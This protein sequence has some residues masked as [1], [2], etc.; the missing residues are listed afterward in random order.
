[1]NI[2]AKHQVLL[3]KAVRQSGLRLRTTN[4]SAQP[5][6]FAVGVTVFAPEIAVFLA[7]EVF[8]LGRCFF[9]CPGWVLFE[10]GLYAYD[11]LKE[12]N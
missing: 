11:A 3:R 2:L 10:L 8:D 6:P 12:R 9:S 5:G 4:D 1:M 7:C